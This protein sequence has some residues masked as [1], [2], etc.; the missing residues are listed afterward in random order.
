MSPASAE[1]TECV[2]SPLVA[3]AGDEDCV[4]GSFDKLSEEIMPG[5]PDDACGPV[6][7]G[8]ADSHPNKKSKIDLNIKALS[9]ISSS[10]RAFFPSSPSEIYAGCQA[11]PCF[12]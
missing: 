7:G 8:F 1:S 3:T 11:Y 9:E 10:L 6:T 12:P 2:S 5:S 4:N